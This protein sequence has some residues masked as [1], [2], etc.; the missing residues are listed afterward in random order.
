MIDKDI[1]NFEEIKGKAKAFYKSMQPT[2]CPELNEY[3]A[4]NRSGFTHLTRQG[5]LS[6]PKKEQVRRFDILPYAPVIINSPD[7]KPEYRV[8]KQISV[9]K[10]FGSKKKKELEV[11]FWGFSK[12]INGIKVKVVIRQMGNGKKHFF[13]IF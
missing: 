3:I 5:N 2:W 1:P 4:F 13:S 9:I 10:P 8:D 6:R 12:E 11:Q 7:K